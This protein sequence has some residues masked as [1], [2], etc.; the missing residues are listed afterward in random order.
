M[1]DLCQT[2][3]YGNSHAYDISEVGKTVSQNG[4]CE[5]KTHSFRL[6]IEPAFLQTEDES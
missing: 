1:S 6:D 4:R 5:V 2:G 3:C